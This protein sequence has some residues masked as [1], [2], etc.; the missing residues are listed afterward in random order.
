MNHKAIDIAPVEEPGSPITRASRQMKRAGEVAK[1]VRFRSNSNDDMDEFGLEEAH[2]EEVLPKTWE[3]TAKWVIDGIVMGFLKYI[4]CIVAAVIIH[5]DKYTG[6]TFRDSIGI[7]IALQCSSTLITCLYTA[8]FSEVRINIS[9]P[10]IIAALFVVNWAKTLSKSKDYSKEEALPTLLFLIWFSTFVMGI[11]WLFCGLFRLTKII[12]FFPEP[13]VNGF[14]GCI[15]WKVLK[16]A[17]KIALGDQYDTFGTPLTF[18]MMLLALVL[19]SALFALKKRYHHLAMYILPAFL[20]IP[21]SLFWIIVAISGV[22]EENLRASEVLFPRYQQHAPWRLYVEFYGN[23]FTGQNINFGALFD[24]EIIASMIVMWLI[25]LIDSLLKIAATKSSLELDFDVKKEIEVTGV[26][27]MLAACFGVASPGYPQVK[28]NILSY[29][30]I[31]N[32]L[33]RRVGAFVGVFCGLFWIVNVSVTVLN[34]LPRFVFSLLLFYAAMPFL[35][36][37]LVLPLFRMKALDL[38]TIYGIVLVVVLMDLLTTSSFAMIVAVFSG[39]FLSFVSFIH[40]SVQVDVVR[41]CESGEYY[42]SKVVRTYWE[43][44]LLT[45][46]G[47][48][49]QIIQLD[50]FVFFMSASHVFDVVKSIAAESD[51]RDAA[52]QCRFLI[53][54][55]LYVENIDESGLKMLKDIRRYI[56]NHEPHRIDLV[57]TGHQKFRRQFVEFGLIGEK[58]DS[59]HHGP[60]PPVVHEAEDMDH[61]MELCEDLILKRAAKLR[62]FWLMFDSFIKLHKEARERKK[63]QLFEIALGSDIGIDIWKYATLVTKKKNDILCSEGEKIDTVFL[64]QRGRV[65]SYTA[66]DDGQVRRIQTITKGAVINDEC[67]FLNLPVTHTVVVDKESSFWAITKQKLKQMEEKHPKLALAITHHIL[68]YASTVRQRL[69][70]DINGLEHVSKPQ[71]KQSKG[72]KFHIQHSHSLAQNVMK[73]ITDQHNQLLTQSFHWKQ[74]HGD[75]DEHDHDHD[76]TLA[77]YDADHHVHHFKHISLSVAQRKAQ[78][79]KEILEKEHANGHIPTWESTKP[80]LSKVQEAEARKWFDF[81]LQDIVSG[82]TTNK[83]SLPLALCQ[84]AIMDLGIFPTINEVKNMHTVLGKKVEVIDAQGHHT[85]VYKGTVTVGV[86]EFLK[87]IEKLTLKELD[88]AAI[89][90]LHAMFEEFAEDHK[91]T[92]MLSKESL[93]KLMDRLEHHED[94]VELACIMHEWDV[95]HDGFLSF[96]AFVSIVSTHMKLEEL[97]QEMEKDFL[98]LCGLSHEEQMRLTTDQFEELAITKEMLLKGMEEHGGRHGIKFSDNIADEMIYD[99][100]IDMADKQ[101]TFDELITCLEMVGPDEVEESITSSGDNSLWRA[102]SGKHLSFTVSMLEDE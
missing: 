102:P 93:S 42:R 6:D 26:E 84:K 72:G 56:Q 65:T 47:K 1:H 61:G 57:V 74:V 16:Y 48:R 39:I 11:I 18:G 80:H 70:R 4:F 55:F 40:S 19:G 10:D 9:G 71:K 60:A 3:Y 58:H 66:T 69:E 62:S 73:H 2:K 21:L 36:N 86:D 88:H 37:Y 63:Y 83:D 68:R 89:I 85:G 5:D 34:Y 35:E 92:P 91:G 54:D 15:A 94:E 38:A 12:S 25:L 59:H 101:V 7:G 77:Q 29:G 33:D 8:Y 44:A 99:A 46:V 20:F 82:L 24:G 81:H 90:S 17:G 13:V 76:V 100:D 32:K 14:L 78:H 41:K 31:N 87:M 49:V 22:T 97:D 50:G 98:R 27:N 96:D 67:I 30:I 95:E 51:K 28:F 53:L 43:E 23:L 45:R 52:E 75:D 64:L 79:L